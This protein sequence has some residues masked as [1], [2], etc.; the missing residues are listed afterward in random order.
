MDA[1][2]RLF[3]TLKDRG[4]ASADFDRVQGVA[5]RLFDLH[6]PRHSRDRDYVHIRSTQ[7]HDEGYSVVGSYI[8]IDEESSRHPRSITNRVWK[9]VFGTQRFE[10]SSRPLRLGYSNLTDRID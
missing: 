1:L 3:S 10:V 9:P 6:I 5:S 2:Q 4:A 8:G 7:G